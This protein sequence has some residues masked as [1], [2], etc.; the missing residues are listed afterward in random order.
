[1][2]GRQS[3]LAVLMCVAL[4]GASAGCE[5]GAQSPTVLPARSVTGS[6]ASSDVSLRYL[7]ERPPGPGPFPAV[8]IGHGSGE[9]RKEAFQ[10]L[11]TELLT[12]GFAVLRYDKRGVGDSTGTYSTV[13][14]G[15][16]ER[17]FA[18]LS[19]D[20]AAGAEFLRTLPDVDRS[21]VGLMGYSQ[22]G[23]IIPLAAR[24]S[25]PAFIVMMVGPT[26]TV[27]QEIY[28]SRFAEDTT[29]PF[30]ELSKILKEYTGPHGF[31]P[32]PVLEEL[33]VPGLWLLG[34]ADR[35]IPTIETVTIL[36]ALIAGG[37]PYRRVV[38]PFSGHNLNGA[39]IWPD[40][41]VFLKDVKIVK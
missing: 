3:A 18:D 8:V 5:S 27:G 7:L 29:T 36:D 17:M 9:V 21:R 31:D 6:F 24:R 1:M 13:G 19:S 15:N 10:F 11:A 38:Y 26:V 22:A 2:T 35:S 32:R 25:K 37:R 23:W 33:T 34:S 30:D 39:K 12:R 4:V 14:I 40:I 41:E 28:Y 16:S 20:M